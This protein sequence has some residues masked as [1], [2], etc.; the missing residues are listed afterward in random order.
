MQK[1]EQGEPPRP[2]GATDL[3]PA[4]QAELAKEC[5]NGRLLREYVLEL[6]EAQTGYR[7]GKG[8]AV[9]GDVLAAFGKWWLDTI[10]KGETG[11]DFRW[12]PSRQP[13]LFSTFSAK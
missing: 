5:P 9:S 13:I 1:I 7:V 10:S 11:L 12:Y 3:P 6:F 4:V 8:D 2:L